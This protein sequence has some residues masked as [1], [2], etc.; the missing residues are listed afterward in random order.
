MLIT[1]TSIKCDCGFTIYSKQTGDVGVL[2]MRV[3]LI[4][5]GYI[6]IKCPKCKRFD[7]SVPIA[8]LK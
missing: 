6:T 2:K 8:L 7:E 4:K 3:A 1:E 5:D